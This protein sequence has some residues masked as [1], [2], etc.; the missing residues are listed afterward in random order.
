MSVLFL[1]ILYTAGGGE[2][3]GGGGGEGMEGRDGRVGGK[4]MCVGIEG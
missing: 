4:G 2:E 3:R 1:G